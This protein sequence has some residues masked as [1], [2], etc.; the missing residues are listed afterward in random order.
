MSVSTES[1]NVFTSFAGKGQ[2]TFTLM[3][4]TFWPWIVPIASS[5]ALVVEPHVRT[6]IFASFGPAMSTAG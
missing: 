1:R 3:R 6:P 5:T 4:L 2:R